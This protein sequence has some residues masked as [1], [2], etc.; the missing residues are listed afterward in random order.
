MAFAEMLTAV[1]P[2]SERV[3]VDDVEG[4]RRGSD[5]AG[6]AART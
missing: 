4:R 3:T 6:P 1:Q 2:A 5:A